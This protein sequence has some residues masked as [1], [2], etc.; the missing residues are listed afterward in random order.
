MPIEE[1]KRIFQKMYRTHYEDKEYFFYD[2]LKECILGNITDDCA[3][4]ELLA[5][6]KEIKLW[7]KYKKE[8]NDDIQN[9][10]VPLFTI[11][12]EKDRIVKWIGNCDRFKTRREQYLC[13]PALYEYIDKLDDRQYEIMACVIC[14]F[15][16]ADKITLTDKGNEGGVDFFAR[17]P[18]SDSAHFLFGIKGPLRIVGQCKKYASKDNV[19]HMKE[20][21]Q[22]LEH[23]HNKSYRVGEIL[24]DWFKLERGAILGWHI[25]NLGHQAGALDI[26]KNFGILVSDSKQIIDIICSAKEMRNYKDK[27]DCLRK[28][29]MI[30][31]RY[32]NIYSKT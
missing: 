26:A 4:A 25:S 29:Y 8:N 23:V 22:T 9:G 7:N 27:V 1:N 16:G 32:L 21:V 11:V 6:N 2:I 3:K 12:D 20:F 24:P 5:Q 28:K 14:E 31:E 13:R 10:I 17:I 30:E 19:G 18:F 15:L